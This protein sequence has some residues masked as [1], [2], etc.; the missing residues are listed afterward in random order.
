MF[1]INRQVY[2]RS[3]R[4]SQRKQ[5]AAQVVIDLV[6]GIRLQMPRIGTRK[7][8]HI[9]NEHLRTAKVG[10]DKLFCIMKANRML[11]MPKRSYRT[12]THT[13]HRFK[14]HKDLICNLTLTRPEQVWVSDITYLGGRK[15]HQYLAM[16][17]DAYSKRIMGYNLS[18]SLKTEGA[19]KALQMAIKNRNYQTETL[20]H[21]SDKGFQYCSDEY[22]D[23][24]SRKGIKCSMTESY[25]PYSNAIAERVNGILKHEFLLEEY[26][27]SI[28][29]MSKI[30]KQSIQIYNTQ[31][32]HVSCYMH[33]PDKMHQ[34]RSISVKTYKNKR[35]RNE[36][37]PI[38]IS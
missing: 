24:L 27:L 32:P 21:H 35:D 1:G 6:K 10:R 26:S 34:Q 16:V 2:Y 29:E 25:D 14:K 4:S 11:V 18:D 20:I 15:N 38:A 9:L 36:H 13:H 37:N 8:Y 17:T 22:Q 30:I 3:L 19:I 7:L 33:T 12:T 28:T 5:Q 23:L 31:R